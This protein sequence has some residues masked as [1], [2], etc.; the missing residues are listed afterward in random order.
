MCYSIAMCDSGVAVSPCITVCRRRS[1]SVCGRRPA[2]ALRCA[3]EPRRYRPP[4]MK[5]NVPHCGADPIPSL[6]PTLPSPPRTPP[7]PASDGWS[8]SGPPGSLRRNERPPRLHMCV[9]VC[10]C[11]CACVRA[12][13]APCACACV[14]ARVRVCV[15][16]WRPEAEPEFPR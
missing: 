8:R 4:L 5:L 14:R 6:S 13:G 7:S 9:C 12:R 11:A 1:V 15:Q 3:A 10:A 2:R 16:S